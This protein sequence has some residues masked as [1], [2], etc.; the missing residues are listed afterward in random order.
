VFLLVGK[1]N[2]SVFGVSNSRP[3]VHCAMS[4]ITL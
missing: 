3:L 4:S 1:M 2:S